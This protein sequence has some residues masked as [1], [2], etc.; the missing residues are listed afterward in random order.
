M[1]TLCCFLF[2]LFSF[3]ESY[4]QV[5]LSYGP[6]FSNHYVFNSHKKYDATDVLGNS[7][8]F[9]RIS[10][11]T[12]L[13]SKHE[14]RSA[15]DFDFYWSFQNLQLTYQYWV[16]EN[17]FVGLTHQSMTYY[18]DDSTFDDQNSSDY[19]GYLKSRQLG[20][21]AGVRKKTS[22]FEFELSPEILFGGSRKS[23]EFKD[24]IQ[25]NTNKRTLRS[26]TF[27]IDNM[28]SIKLE[29]AIMWHLFQV[30][31]VVVGLRYTGGIKHDW[32]SFENRSAF[33][34][35]TKSNALIDEK[36]KVRHTMIQF[37]NEFALLL[38]FK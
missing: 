6:F 22:S 25:S 20:L 3:I 33:Y 10:I 18:V 23:K 32:F 35:W 29:G 17:F 12:T 21:N 5:D 8:A 4:G 27:R 24:F 38:R 36:Y 13:M 37:Q 1:K 19:Y 7:D 11:S 34:E 28:L 14:I 16:K 30:R 15:F 2:I 26:E 9:N 31:D